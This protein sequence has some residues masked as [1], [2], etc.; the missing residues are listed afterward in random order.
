VGAA[1]AV[2]DR[3]DTLVGFFGVGLLPT[4]GGDPFG[5]RRAALG[6]LRTVVHHRARAPLGALTRAAYIGY[7]A[8]LTVEVGRA[9]DDVREFVR[10]RF[11]HALTRE[12]GKP[13]D[14]VRACLDADADDPVDALERI[15]AVDAVRRTAA[16]PGVVTAFERVFNIW[17]QAE[18]RRYD[19][20]AGLPAAP[21]LVE[22]DELA[23]LETYAAVREQLTALLTDRRFVPALELVAQTLP[24]PIDRFFANVMVMDDVP[25]RRTARLR[26]MR[27]MAEDVGAVAR[28]DTLAASARE[29]ARG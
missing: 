20:P 12:L 24:G 5:L 15:E 19:V 1:L 8:A 27:Q 21:D 26:L 10:E 2:A 6:L 4:S 9:V 11:E 18:A 17:K 3:I 16:F 29:A 13:I 22:P 23:L 25:A 14:V 7:G 28:F